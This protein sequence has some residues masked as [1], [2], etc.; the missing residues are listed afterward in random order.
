MP[1]IKYKAAGIIISKDKQNLLLAIGEEKTPEGK[2]ILLNPGGT[3]GNDLIFDSESNRDK[4][5]ESTLG[6]E[7][8]EELSLTP[9]MYNAVKVFNAQAKAATVDMLLDMDC[10]LIELKPEAKI[11]PNFIEGDEDHDVYMAVWININDFE[12]VSE[13]EFTLKPDKTFK[14]IVKE[15]DGSVK[16]LDNLN[17][18]DF[19]LT[20]ITANRVIP[21]VIKR[22]L[23]G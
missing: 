15:S 4:L 10:Y 16:S 11:I 3:V 13:N 14:G 21:E 19:F 7:L 12:Q 20:A 23:L 5:M 8:E 22:N 18:K 6:K 9:D 17:S 2:L 1:K